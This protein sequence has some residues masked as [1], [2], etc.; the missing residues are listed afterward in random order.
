MWKICWYVRM[1][2]HARA[3]TCRHIG[4][5]VTTHRHHA[6]SVPIA[7]VSYTIVVTQ[8]L[9][10]CLVRGISFSARYSWSFLHACHDQHIPFNTKILT[11]CSFKYFLINYLW[12]SNCTIISSLVLSPLFHFWLRPIKYRSRDVLS[13]C[14]FLYHSFT[15]IT[16]H[17]IHQ[18]D[19]ISLLW[20]K[21]CFKAS[22]HHLLHWTE[23][24]QLLLICISM[25]WIEVRDYWREDL[26]RKGRGQRKYSWRGHLYCDWNG[27]TYFANT[28]PFMD[29]NI[30]WS[31]VI[32]LFIMVGAKSNYLVARLFGLSIQHL[33]KWIPLS[34]NMIIL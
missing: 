28:W 27:F 18:F 25:Y 4:T 26:T 13:L 12:K 33:L 22:A 31:S 17:A 7:P 19:S 11:K 14:F 5:H 2:I 21:W 32:W 15:Y 20:L 9:C 1:Q 10:Q 34:K 30:K 29:I 6:A 24:E 23:R 3:H 8:P 16:K